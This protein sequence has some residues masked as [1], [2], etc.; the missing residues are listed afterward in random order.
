MGVCRGATEKQLIMKPR[1]IWCALLLAGAVAACGG[2][3]DSVEHGAARV[4]GPRSGGRSDGEG[5]SMS[6]TIGG[7]NQEAVEATVNKT[8][9]RIERCVEQGRGRLR[10]LGGAIAVHVDVDKSGRAIAAYF[11]RSTLGEHK[12]EG[13]ILTAYKSAQWPR[14]VGG[15]VGQIDQNLD[16]AHGGVD[17]ALEWSSDDLAA[18]MNSDGGSSVAFTEL[19]AQLDGC[20]KEL[21]ASRLSVTMYLDEDGLAQ[22]VGVATGDEKGSAAA[23]CAETVVKTTSFPA[24]GGSYAKVTVSVP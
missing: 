17:T 8:R 24:P 15:E 12:T 1:L 13:C 5:M 22:A 11:V 3:Q 19:R 10:Y 20:R 23:A 18:K 7:L 4:D 6:A 14:P 2:S 21:G 9:S 16:F